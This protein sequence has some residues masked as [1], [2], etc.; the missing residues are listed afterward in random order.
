MATVNICYN[1]NRFTF[2][3]SKLLA[4]TFIP[5]PDNKPFV[6]HKDGNILNNNLKNL[7]WATQKEIYANEIRLGKLHQFTSKQKSKQTQLIN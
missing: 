6:M 4:L 2:T 1:N 7:Q 3:L 5:N